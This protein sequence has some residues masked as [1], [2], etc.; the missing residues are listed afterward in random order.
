MNV[1]NP[2]QSAESLI[3]RAN[4]VLPAGSFGNMPGD[5]VLERGKAGRVWD[6]NGTEYIDFLLGSGPMFV[7]H[8]HPDV[9]KAITEQAPQ[10][11]TFFANN[12]S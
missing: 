1:L 3:S 10:G 8:A 7:G 2:D 4:K 11:T 12:Q 5:I 6:I 9:T